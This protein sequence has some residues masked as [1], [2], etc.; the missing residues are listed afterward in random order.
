MTKLSNIEFNESIKNIKL[1]AILIG[2]FTVIGAIAILS[3]NPSKETDN[4]NNMPQTVDE[5]DAIQLADNEI[6]KTK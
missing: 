2:S 6:I 5:I 1:P 3:S 4:Y